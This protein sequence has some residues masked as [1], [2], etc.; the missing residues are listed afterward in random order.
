MANRPPL[1]LWDMLVVPPERSAAIA[2]KDKHVY[3]IK[4]DLELNLQ[5]QP[6][7]RLKRDKPEPLV[8]SDK[9]NET[10]SIEPYGQ[11]VG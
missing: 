9:P 1:G 3:P 7:R 11:S 2:W 10:W 5:I 6:E 8:V 4:S